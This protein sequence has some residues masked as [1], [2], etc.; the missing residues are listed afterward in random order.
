MRSS[1]GS[2]SCLGLF[3]VAVGEQLRRAFEVGKQHGD[4]LALA[5]QRAAGGEDLLREIGR[6]VGEW[7]PGLGTPRADGGCG[8]VPASPVQTKPRPASSRTCGWAV[9]EFV[10]ESVEA[11]SQGEL[12]LAGSD[13]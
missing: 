3:G 1:T 10:F 7:A 5:F 8:R 13:R 4:L 2:R 11:S 9:E 12:A 6:G